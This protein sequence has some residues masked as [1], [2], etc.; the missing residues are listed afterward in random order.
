[1][2]WVAPSEKGIALRPAGC[3]WQAGSSL[4]DKAGELEATIA[5]NVSEILES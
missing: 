5:S 1:M 3:A 2:H 4:K